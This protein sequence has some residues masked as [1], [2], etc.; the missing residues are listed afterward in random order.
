L[1]QHAAFAAIF[2]F[3]FLRRHCRYAI[4]CHSDAA[5]PKASRRVVRADAAAP[6]LLMISCLPLHAAAFA[7]LFILIAAAAMTPEAD[8]FTY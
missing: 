4:Y 7:R 6:P 3:R 2:A 1:I 5:S 8:Y